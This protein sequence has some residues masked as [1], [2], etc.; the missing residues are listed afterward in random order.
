LTTMPKLIELELNKAYKHIENT[1]KQEKLEKTLSKHPW[2]HPHQAARYLTL[3]GDE[4]EELFSTTEKEIMK[5]IRV[6]TLLTTPSR[7]EKRLREKGFRTRP[8]PYISYG[9]VVVEQPYSPGATIEYLLG[10][11]TIQGPA[12]MLAVPALKPE[13][14][15]E[16][17]IV[18]MCAGAG[19]K[20]TQISQH[21]PHH[22]IIALDTNR[23][24]LAALKNNA[25]RLAAANIIAVNMDARKTPEHIKAEKILLDAPCSGEGLLPFPARRRKRSFNDIISRTKIQYSLLEAAVK[26]LTE[27]GTLVYSTCSLAVEENEYVISLAIKNSDIEASHNPLPGEPGVEDYANL[28]IDPRVKNACKRFYPHIHHTEGFTVCILRKK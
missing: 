22:T 18:D 25:S 17:P 20:T 4:A 23:R 12:S 16:K 14:A 27:E 11:Y 28:P 24:K 26:A 10:Y 8:H 7:L 5:T 9:I 3:L 13:E 2:L 1:I 19:I 15:K 6:N 21:N